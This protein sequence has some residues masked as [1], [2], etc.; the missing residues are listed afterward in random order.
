MYEDNNTRQNIKD[1]LLAL[2]T[3]ENLKTYK[4]TGPTSIG[5]SFTLFRLSRLSY[6][7]AY[8]NLKILTKNKDDLFKSYNMIIE[9]LERFDIENYIE[10]LEQLI[11]EC[12]KDNKSFLNLLVNI[13]NFLNDL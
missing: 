2:K 3:N 8:I 10:D 11:N 6:N 7:I 13:M 12:Y 5:K 1:N 4:L 9:E